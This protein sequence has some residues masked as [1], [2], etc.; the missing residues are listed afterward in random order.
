MPISCQASFN[1][2]SFGENERVLVLW[3]L[4]PS[5]S[6]KMND[7][8][9]YWFE[10]PR[11]K[12]EAARNPRSDKIIEEMHPTMRSIGRKNSNTQKYLK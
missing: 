2:K 6:E 9:I 8:I 4:L 11:I 3:N 1:W 10:R 7:F 12:K 5:F